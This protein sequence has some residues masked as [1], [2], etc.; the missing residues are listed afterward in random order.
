MSVSLKLVGLRRVTGL[1]LL[2]SRL[3]FVAEGTPSTLDQFEAELFGPIM[4]I[5]QQDVVGQSLPS[6]THSPSKHL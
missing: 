6:R 2:P 3:R 5:L 4:T 1:T